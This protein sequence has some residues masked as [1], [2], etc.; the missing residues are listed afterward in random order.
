MSSSAAHC[1]SSAASR[2]GRMV[3]L[4]HM[5]SVVCAVRVSTSKFYSEPAASAGSRHRRCCR[6]LHPAN[7]QI[8]TGHEQST[9]SSQEDG[10]AMSAGLY[11]LYGDPLITA[12]IF[13]LNS[14]VQT[15]TLDITDSSTTTVYSS[16][17]YL[18][19]GPIAHSTMLQ[20][21]NAS[22]MP[23]HLYSVLSK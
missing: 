22:Y 11:F 5:S 19:S 10:R 4:F 15:S 3:L 9:D 18:S 6:P 2:P 21:H 8:H 20:L 1:S 12:S 14:R 7:R 16:S 17:Y 23:E 13:G